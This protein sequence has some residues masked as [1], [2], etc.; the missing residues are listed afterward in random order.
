MRIFALNARLHATPHHRIAHVTLHAWHEWY[1]L[2]V[3]NKSLL[4][5]TRSISL[6]NRSLLLVA[7][8]SL[9]YLLVNRSISLLIRSRLQVEVMDDAC[10]H[11][12]Q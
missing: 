10:A 3:V 11:A 12:M 5:A 7:N 6:L 8:K 2:L 1:L 4:Q 9:T